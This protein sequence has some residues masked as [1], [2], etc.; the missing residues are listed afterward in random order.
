MVP[1]NSTIDINNYFRRNN[2]TP[3]QL[4]ELVRKAA[5]ITKD[6]LLCKCLLM[7]IAF[8]RKNRKG[9]DC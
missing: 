8:E 7:R 9:I 5:H 4:D 6:E 1:F 2:L 3:E